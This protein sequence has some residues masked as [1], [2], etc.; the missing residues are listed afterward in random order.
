MAGTTVIILI[1][2][3]LLVFQQAYIFYLE[4]NHSKERKDLYSRIMAGTLQD[5]EATVKK[6]RPPPK[7]GS[8][9]KSKAGE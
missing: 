2:I 6:E 1:L 9:F 5:Y 7:S 3:T 4:N 8:Y